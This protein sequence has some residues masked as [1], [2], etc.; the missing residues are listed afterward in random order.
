VTT[1]PDVVD[2][3][4]HHRFTTT[5]DGHVAELTYERSSDRLVLVHTGVPKAIDGHGVGSALILAAVDAAAADDLTVVPRCP[6]ARRYL[7][8]HPDVAARVKIDWPV[9]QR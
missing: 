9:D 1:R 2:D 3:A 6:F 7:R 5:V 8:E 4:A